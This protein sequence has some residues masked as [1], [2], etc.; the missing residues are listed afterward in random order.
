M[1]KMLN[2][3]KSLNF[4]YR[5]SAQKI[6]KDYI[7]LKHMVMPTKILINDTEKQILNSRNS[8]I[9]FADAF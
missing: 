7:I 1:L 6:Y 4:V 2:V 3:K 8:N 5:P 9:S